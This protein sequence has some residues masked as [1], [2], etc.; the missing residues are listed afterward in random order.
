MN[1]QGKAL[2]G[3]I[4]GDAQ[5]G[6]RPPFSSAVSTEVLC[7]E[8]EH[9]LALRLNMDLTAPQ[10][11]RLFVAVTKTNQALRLVVEAGLNY[12]SIRDECEHGQFLDL[13]TQ[14][15]V[16]PRRAREAMN[17]ARALAAMPAARVD[18][19]MSLGK[20]KVL[21]LANADAEVVEVLLEGGIDKIDAL[22]VRAMNDQIRELKA[23]L[24]DTQTER[25]A[26]EAE[27][28]N[29][30][31]RIKKSSGP[32]TDHL[33][34]VIADARGEITALV[35]QAELCVDSIRV[36]SAEVMQMNGAAL[37]WQGPTLRLAVAGLLA[38]RVQ[39]D[40][41][42]GQLVDVLPAGNL[43]IDTSSPLAYLSPQE[44]AETAGSWARLVKVHEHEAALRAWE[45]EQARP[46][47]KGRPSAKPTAPDA[48]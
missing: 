9:A 26:A 6:E 38:V 3:Q 42:V 22:S 20:S 35:K 18:E 13:L 45:R 33:P 5:N 40:A 34:V 10:E 4:K 7:G 28:A 27:I 19:V 30:Q 29:L 23:A 43:G 41:L 47:G 2:M 44:V 37:E 24:A 25:D 36:S 11:D 17:L 15:G 48:A 8:R 16:D 46:R 14:A 12:L 31:K 21:A 39:I 1:K 32:R